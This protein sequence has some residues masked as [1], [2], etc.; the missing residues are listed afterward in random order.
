[1]KDSLFSRER[2]NILE[3]GAGTGTVAL[4]LS[5]LRSALNPADAGTIFATDLPS[6]MP[7]L[8]YNISA[9]SHLFS[10]ACPQ[11]TVLDWHDEDLSEEIRSVQDGYDAIV[12]A[13][14]T[15]N[16]SSFPSLV[17]TL[18]TL[19]QLNAKRNVKP[20]LI[21]LGYK[22]RDPAERTLWEMALRIGVVFQ[23]F[24]G[25]S[26]SGGQE[27]EVWVGKVETELTP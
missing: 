6:A 27:V 11:A 16:T 13:D 4:T 12:M 17:R 2:R 5:V 18:S 20:P 25:R 26:G 10:S 9:N 23:R 1:M 22:E 21:L 8:E 14:V 15:Y 7:L 24:G 3:L 19:L